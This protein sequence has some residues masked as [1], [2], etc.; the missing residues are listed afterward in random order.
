MDFVIMFATIGALI[1]SAFIIVCLLFFVLNQQDG[2]QNTA[3]PTAT[4]TTT[5]TAKPIAIPTAT[6]KANPKEPP[7]ANPKATPKETPTAT[8]KTNRDDMILT[9]S[10]NPYG[11]GTSDQ[12]ITDENFR[13][14]I[15]PPSHE[16]TMESK[17]LEYEKRL[18]SE[19]RD[20]RK[21]QQGRISSP[22]SEQDVYPD[23]RQS[24][25]L[26]ASNTK[27]EE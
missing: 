17:I 7:K 10:P 12:K 8:P 21:E 18:L 26:A 16:E 20:F 22:V 11:S 24:R 3:K 19:S 4:H 9:V 14:K 23:L 1:L 25:D 27:K 13:E 5:Y 6:P 2:Q 15:Q